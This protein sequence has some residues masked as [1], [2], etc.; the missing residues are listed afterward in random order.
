MCGNWLPP[1]GRVR[2]SPCRYLCLSESRHRNISIRL[3][4]CTAQSLRPSVV[5]LLACCRGAESL[6]Q[7]AF[8]SLISARSC[9]PA[10][11]AAKNTRL[12]AVA[13]FHQTHERTGVRECKPVQP[14]TD[15]LTT[16]PATHHP[17]VSKLATQEQAL[18]NT[19]ESIRGRWSTLLA[20]IR[21]DVVD[22]DESWRLSLSGQCDSVDKMLRETHRHLTAL[23]A[24]VLL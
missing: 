14:T 7:P 21:E 19:L 2:S 1:H 15:E 22:A 9:S 16:R 20:A 23:M 12:H 6:L 10:S 24:T 13:S 17:Q 8:P 11:E 5:F 18:E 4:R 3:L